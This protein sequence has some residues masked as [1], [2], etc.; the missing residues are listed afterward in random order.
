MIPERRGRLVVSILEARVTQIAG[1][2]ASGVVEEFA[3]GR[4]GLPDL[5]ELR[6]R[7]AGQPPRLRVAVTLGLDVRAVHV[8]DHRNRTLVGLS[9][10]PRTVGSVDLPP[11]PRTSLLRVEETLPA[12]IR[13]VKGLIEGQQVTEVLASRVPNAEGPTGLFIYFDQVIHPFHVN[14]LVRDGL[15]GESRVVELG[16]RSCLAALGAPTQI[17]GESGNRILLG[18]VA[19]NRGRR[20]TAVAVGARHSVTDVAQ[21]A[22]RAPRE[23]LL[24][25]LPDRDV[26]VV[27]AFLVVLH[28]AGNHQRD[29]VLG[30][31][32]GI[33]HGS[34]PTRSPVL[35]LRGRD[36]WLGAAGRRTWKRVREAENH[37]SKNQ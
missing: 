37:E 3:L 17:R 13:P 31:H 21:L 14:L 19:P 7:V 36:L 23:D 18:S 4:I 24:F 35:L 25:E 30:N 29:P 15:D 12:G 16:E 28:D 33:Q 11:R 20:I 1:I 32:V 9:L 27:P 8:G 34:R 6:I 22:P 2:L 10:P 5:V 26:V